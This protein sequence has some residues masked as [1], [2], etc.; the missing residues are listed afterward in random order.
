MT[1]EQLAREYKK[2]L[3]LLNSRIAVLK[4][5]LKKLEK[6]RK[7]HKEEI[8]ELRQRLEP[9]MAMQRDLREITRE[10]KNYYIRSWWRS[11]KYTCNNRRARRA[12]PFFR[13]IFEENMLD[14]LEPDTEDEEGFA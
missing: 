13:N 10:V 14:K 12:V 8:R 4:N 6:K 1:N 3:Q 5:R 9:L 2:S 7:L 11:E